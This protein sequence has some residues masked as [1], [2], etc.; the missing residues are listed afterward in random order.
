MTLLLQCLE[1]FYSFFKIGIMGFGGGY[2]MMSMIIAESEKYSITAAQFADLNALDMIVPGPIAINS[3]TYVGYIYAGIPGAVAATVGVS[4]PSLIIIALVMRFIARYRENKIMKGFLSGV[5]P[6]AV[7][8]IG[9]A[10]LTIAAGVL[11]KEGAEWSGFFADP[12]GTASVFLFAIF[13][14]TAVL[15]IKFKVN[16]ILLTLAAGV[17]G[18]VVSFF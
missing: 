13:V 1:L 2:A 4:L 12:L 15:N 3:A 16:P 18:A 6:A 8:L 9:A 7:G 11:I 17:I 14:I 10:A 5:K